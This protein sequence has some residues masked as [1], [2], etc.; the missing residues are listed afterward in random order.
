MFTSTR[1]L[2]AAA[3]SDALA[4]V[5][6]RAFTT[7]A[8]AASDWLWITRSR[9]IARHKDPAV[10]AQLRHLDDNIAATYEAIS[11]LGVSPDIVGGSEEE[12]TENLKLAMIMAEN[13]GES[14]QARKTFTAALPQLEFYS[15]M[16]EGRRAIIEKNRDDN[17]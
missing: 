8:A 15:Q 5:A 10:E 1:L 7:T 6:T 13:R 4:P 9:V 14:E 12:F 3:S 17:G 16:L 11:D 2:C